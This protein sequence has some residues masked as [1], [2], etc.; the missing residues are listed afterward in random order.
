MF[1]RIKHLVKVVWLFFAAL[2][3]KAFSYNIAG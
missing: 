2:A 3:I 1:F